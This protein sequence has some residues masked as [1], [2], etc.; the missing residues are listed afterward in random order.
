[1]TLVDQL[2]EEMRCHHL[3][4]EG[5]RSARRTAVHGEF[6]CDNVLIVVR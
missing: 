6:I 3:P 4:T 2:N 5:D 1:M